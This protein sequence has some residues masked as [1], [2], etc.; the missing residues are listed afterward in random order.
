MSPT[1]R[2][3]IIAIFTSLAV[4]TDY[5][6]GPITNVKLVFTLVFASAYSFGLKI[7]V[8]I[9][10]LTEFIWGIVSPYGSPTLIIV[11][12]MGATVI[13]ALAGWMASKIWSRNINPVSYLNLVFGSIIAVCAFAWDTITNFGTGLL[14]MGA[15]AATFS[16]FLIYE[17]NPFTLYFMVMHELG[18]FILGGALA[19]V[20]IVYFLKA[21]GVRTVT[22]HSKK[23]E[24]TI[25]Q[26]LL[27]T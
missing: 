14:M 27:P 8:T 15:K 25:R 17:A 2:I 18:D 16:G 12:L 1:Q 4:A 11:F 26:S 19:P 10:L 6:M 3:S 21:F 22:V 20:I 24:V 7:G 23:Q 9:A 13:Y 5:A